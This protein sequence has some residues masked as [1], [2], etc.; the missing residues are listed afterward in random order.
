MRKAVKGKKAYVSL[1]TNL[2]KINLMLHT[3]VVN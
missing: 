1:R 2:G 3:D